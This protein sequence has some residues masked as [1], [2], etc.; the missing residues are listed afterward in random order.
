MAI[1][2]SPEKQ[3]EGKNKGFELSSE[4]IPIDRMV[5]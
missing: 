2:L 5:S 1:S 3:L 4:H